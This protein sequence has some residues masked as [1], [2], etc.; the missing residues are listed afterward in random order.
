MEKIKFYYN[1]W[2]ELNP[3][4]FVVV[5]TFLSFLLMVPMVITLVYFDVQEDEL[6]TIKRGDFSHLAFFVLVV[7]VAPVFETF[8]TQSLIIR[9]IQKL[10]KNRFHLLTVSIS[11]IL[12][13]YLH[14]GYSIWY[15]FL[16]FPLGLLLAE[17]YI[18]FQKEKSLVFG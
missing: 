1:K 6:G 11:A 17:T 2:S 3:L 4:A 7:V 13:A 12:F 9:L 10:F 16:I 18:I 5:T 8:L 15:P 14:L